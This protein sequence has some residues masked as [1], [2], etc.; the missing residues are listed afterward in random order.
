V[1]AKSLKLY[2]R[3]GRVSELLQG[4]TKKCGEVQVQL[5]SPFIATLDGDKWSDLRP[6]S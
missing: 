5:H 6:S 2:G 4:G 1:S 3:K